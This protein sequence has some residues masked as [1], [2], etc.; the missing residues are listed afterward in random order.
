MGRKKNIITTSVLM[1]GVL[2]AAA[3][4]SYFQLRPKPDEVF[5]NYVKKGLQSESLYQKQTSTGT[6][7]KEQ[8]EGYVKLPSKDLRLQ[9]KVTCSSDA[10][11]Q[12]IEI[13]AT[14][15][16]QNEKSYIRLDKISGSYTD[17]E[18]SVFELPKLWAPVL[19]QWYEVA[20]PEESIT[21]QLDNKVMAFNSYIMAPSSNVDAIAKEIVDSNV[22]SYKSYRVKDGNYVYQFV[23]DKNAYTA[24]FKN[25]FPEVDN[26]DVIMENIFGD[27]ATLESQVTVDKK[28]N[29]IEENL[30]A[31]TLCSTVFSVYVTEE[32]GD[33]VSELP[34]TAKSDTGIQIDK[35]VN[36]KPFD[37]LYDDMAP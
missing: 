15:Q 28:G 14:F 26:L 22:F 20:D 35:I 21:E 6:G 9:S 18:G 36:A 25:K 5:Y 32:A 10:S 31:E 17:E 11:G 3:A 34:A 13:S 27:K 30:P 24:L 7:I 23:A 4:F 1:L 8:Y 37:T 2:L 19:G 33:F 29:F 12:D 16:Q